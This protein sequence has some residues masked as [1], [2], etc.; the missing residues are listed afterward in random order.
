MPSNTGSLPA[1]YSPNRQIRHLRADSAPPLSLELLRR[2]IGVSFDEREHLARLRPG[3]GVVTGRRA[4]VEPVSI[5]S[6]RVAM[7]YSCYSQ[8]NT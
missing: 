4:C 3:W 8:E 2:E 1:R 5:I 7:G 6:A